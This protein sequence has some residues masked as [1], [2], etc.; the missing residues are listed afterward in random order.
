MPR[1]IN[2]KKIQ[3][4]EWD[5]E[6][7]K[8]KTAEEPQADPSTN[9]PEYTG[10]SRDEAEF[11]YQYEYMR[12]SGVKSLADKAIANCAVSSRFF[13][14]CRGYFPDT[15]WLKIPAERRASIVQEFQDYFLKCPALFRCGSGVFT[16]NDVEMEDVFGVGPEGVMHFTAVPFVIFWHHSDGDIR[17]AFNS[18]LKSNAPPENNHCKIKFAGKDSRAGMATALK[19]LGAYRLCPGKDVITGMQTTKDIRGA[20]LYS[21]RTWEAKAESARLMLASW[22]D[23]IGGYLAR[24]AGTAS[25]LCEKLSPHN[26]CML[27]KGKLED[28][29][30]ATITLWGAR[31]YL[32]LSDDDIKRRLELV[33]QY[34]GDLEP[35]RILRQQRSAKLKI[36]LDH[37]GQRRADIA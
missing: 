31:R 10:C 35:R 36:G 13:E 8:R 14:L 5:F 6:T 32:I 7:P 28:W 34:G 26:R 21:E 9:V 33:C 24:N 18:W 30:T 15:P 22:S 19:Q 29:L 23:P 17:K 1:D 37:N 2:K 11:C 25:V 3:R 16:G 4:E 20:P 12:A 27:G